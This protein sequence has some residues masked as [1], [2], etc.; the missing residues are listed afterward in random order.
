MFS[1][2]PIVAGTFLAGFLQLPC[3]LVAAQAITPLCQPVVSAP[4]IVSHEQIV[5][6]GLRAEP[7]LINTGGFGFAWPDTQM[8]VIKT[9]NGY[10]FLTSDGALHPRQMWQGHWVGNNTYGSVT[11]TGF[12][13]SLVSGNSQTATLSQAFSNPLV[14]SVTPNNPSEPVSGGQVTFTGPGS[15]AGATLNTSPAT[16]GKNGQAHVSAIA[17]ATA[18]S[19]QVSATASGVTSAVS[20]NLTN[21]TGTPG[22]AYQLV[23]GQ[24]PSDAAAGAANSPAV[25]VKI[26]DSY[27]TV[28]KSNTSTVTLKLSSGTFSTGSTSVTASAVSGVA[29]FSTLKINTAGSYTLS[30]TDGA[31]IGTGA[32]NGFTINPGAANQL[33]FGQQ[34]SN[35][36][37]GVPINPAVTVKV[38]DQYFNV[39]TS[40]TSTVTLTLSSGTFSTSLSTATASAVSGV[41]TFSSLQIN[42]AGT[43]TLSGTDGS[44]KA[45]GASNSFI[46]SP[47]AASQLVFGQQPTNATAGVAISPAVTVKVEDQYFNVVKID[48]TTVILKLSSGTFSTSSTSATASAV[49]GVA[50]FSTLQI[51]TAGTYTLSGTDGAL[52]GTGASNSFTISPAAA[53][54]LVFSLQPSDSI[55]GEAISP[56]VTVKVEDQYFNLVP[57]NTSTVK[58]TLS[59]GTFSTGL[60]TA[61]ASAVNGVASF[62]NLIIN[63]A[64]TNTLNGTDGTLK[65]TGASNS[66]TIHPGAAN[67][68]VFGQQPTNGTAGVAISPAVTVKVEDQY[69]NVVKSNT[70]TV[71]LTLNS[72]TFSTSLS[73]ATASAVSGVAT[74]S[75]LQINTAGTYTLSGTDGALKATGFSN[76]FTISPAAAS[77]LVFGQQPSDA[78]AGVAISPAVTV[79]VEDQYF[80]VVK[81]NTSTVSLK[82]SSGTFSTGSTS[83]TASAVSGVA[84][85]STLKINT[86]GTY[87][88]SG[89]DGALTGTG[90]S[91]S[92][93]INPATASAYRIGAVSTTPTAGANDQLT[94]TLV[95]QYGN[96]EKGF[97]GD[98]TLTFSGLSTSGTAYVPTVTNKGSN[99]IKQGTSELITFTNGVSTAGGVLIAYTA[100][101]KTLNVTDSSALSSTKT[102]GAGVNLTVKPTTATLLV[103]TTS[104]AG[105]YTNFPFTTQP[106]VKSEDVYGNVSIV[107][108][109]TVDN[110]TIS[111]NS[112]PGG[113]TLQGTKT[114]N[115]VA[116]SGTIVFSG[117]SVSLKGTYTLKATAAS[118]LTAGISGSFIDVDMP[119]INRH[120]L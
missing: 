76:S 72:G 1:R 30:G 52:T 22:V 45:T 23:F 78:T 5:E 49:S 41:A 67:Q 55:A 70:S 98:K 105:A 62:G 64:G 113:G 84:T 83:A 16:I 29:T 31:L 107:G 46:I 106:V 15:G 88:L 114:Y 28:V 95:D 75:T 65:A 77:Q 4:I 82:L 13:L 20:F 117:L 56:A 10:E 24:Q 53:N 116:L 12:T 27:G 73:T 109:P 36:T 86:A 8:G 103:F 3:G 47:G 17:N 44:L 97:T 80:N 87:T 6:A 93:S 89:T 81:S 108:L 51:N 60:S 2:L 38:E 32:S 40:N 34:P 21:S 25:T 57:N 85:F 119:P 120:G 14:V 111:I 90:A 50:T 104:P 92:F 91:N 112:G 100:E 39:V 59:S 101:T 118:G 69:F 48:T 26:E 79:K 37:A 68:L 19:Y 11:T 35:A 99:P 42:T 102:G 74:F 94:L 115:I 110:V 63:T 18:G 58:L 9:A 66:F 54:Q 71:S 7:P 43:Y 33:V 96:T 61:T